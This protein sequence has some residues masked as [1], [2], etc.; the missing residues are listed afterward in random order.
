[1]RAV[2]MTFLKELLKRCMQ[3]KEMQQKE[4]Q[5]KMRKR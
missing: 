3:Q 5:N 2:Y 4:S 1:M